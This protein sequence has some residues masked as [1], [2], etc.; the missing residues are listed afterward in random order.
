MTDSCWEA[1]Q[2][3]FTFVYYLEYSPL[4]PTLT[5]VIH[6]RARIPTLPCRCHRAMYGYRAMT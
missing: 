4:L 1:G 3:V 2:G 6:G 5:I